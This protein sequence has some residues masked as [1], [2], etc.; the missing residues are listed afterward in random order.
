MAETFTCRC[1]V[2]WTGQNRSHCGACHVTF[3]GVASFD[4][5]RRIGSTIGRKCLKPES[6]GLTDNG[7]GVWVAPYGNSDGD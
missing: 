3:G 7:A 2:G 6:L 4:K 5:H 1:G